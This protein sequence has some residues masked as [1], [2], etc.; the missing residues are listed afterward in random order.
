VR[1]PYRPLSAQWLDWNSQEE[2]E[3]HDA[4]VQRLLDAREEGRE[5]GRADMPASS[6]PYLTF[7]SEYNAWH[8]GRIETLPKQLKRTA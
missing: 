6:C 1:N 4:A 3:R 7:E 8:E 5:A 2:D